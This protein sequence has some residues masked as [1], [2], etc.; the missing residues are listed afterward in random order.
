M[1]VTYCADKYHVVLG[2]RPEVCGQHCKAQGL[3]ARPSISTDRAFNSISH[4]QTMVITVQI[5][6]EVTLRQLQ[7]QSDEEDD[8]GNLSESACGGMMVA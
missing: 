1:Y 5:T 8:P 2:T 6:T 7:G 4:A 3:R